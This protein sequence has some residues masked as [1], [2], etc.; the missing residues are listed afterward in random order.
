MIIFYSVAVGKTL[1]RIMN[2]KEENWTEEK[3]KI[4]T[5]LKFERTILKKRKSRILRILFT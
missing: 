2:L 5:I 1:I 4:R 3:L